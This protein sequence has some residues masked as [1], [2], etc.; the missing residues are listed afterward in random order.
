MKK[1]KILTIITI[2]ALLFV[3]CKEKPKGE[4][5]GET[6]YYSDFL[7]WKYKPVVMEQMLIFDFNEDAYNL[8]T[9]N[10]EF[11]IVENKNDKIIVTKEIV[12]YKNG[13]KCDNNILKINP[14]EA[15]EYGIAEIKVG[16]EFTNEARTG[17]YTLYLREKEKS[18]LD[19]IDYQE[20]TDGF[21]AKKIDIWNPL[22]TFIFWLAITFI[23]FLIIWR[24]FIRPLMYDTFRVNMLYIIYPEIHTPPLRIKGLIKVVCSKIKQ[25]QSFVNKFFTGKIAF[26]HNDFWEKDIEIIPKNHPK[27]KKGVR[28]R[29]PRIFSV[30]PSSTVTIGTDTEITNINTNSI[31]T[32]KIN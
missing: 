14:S 10:I 28:V 6:K 24:I 27:N 20:L 26:V 2:A 13:E 31:V 7:F 5:W 16:I 3:S 17:Y 21:C 32:L 18:D 22:V 9:N 23:S 15:D 30:S 25:R 4:F 11:E 19:R 8:V 1:N 12:L 29:V